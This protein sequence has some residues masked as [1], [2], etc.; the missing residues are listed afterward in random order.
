M[1]P[2][3][4]YDYSRDELATL[5]SSEPSFRVT[6]IWEGLYGQHKTPDE[7]S[8]L[9]KALRA[10]LNEKLPYGLSEVTTSISDRGDTVKFLWELHDGARVE[11]VLMHY[12]ERSTVCVSSQAGC[13]MGCSFCAT[14]QAGFERHL[15]TGEIVEQVVRASQNAAPNRVDNIVFMG[16][17][18]PLANFE[19]SWEAVRR[20]NQDLGIGA[21]HITMSTVGVIPGILQMAKQ[22]EQV[23]LAVSLHSVDTKVRNKLVP[24]NKRYGLDALADACRVW[25]GAHNRRLSF[26][27]AMIDGVNDREIDA[28]MLANYA[29]PLRAHVNLIPLNPTS[30]FLTRGS[31]LK[32]V[33]QFRDELEDFGV[34]ATVR[35]T[36]GN[37]IDAAC[38][39][40]RA[41]HSVA[42]P[43]PARR[44]DK[45]EK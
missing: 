35:R 33:H 4:R 12:K 39:Q 17:G 32:L 24:L 6:Q 34:T 45:I 37:E 9:P 36:R 28:R 43:T 1:P 20:I 13:A 15:S 5:L 42:V 25:L 27:W 30:G 11:S 7:M 22:P 23:G 41:G 19:S 40:L 21:R 3:S 2:Q 31:P 29:R 18:E 38:G 16:M 14:G 44:D 26:E 10:T 8:N